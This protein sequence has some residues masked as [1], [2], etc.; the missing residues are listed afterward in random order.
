M[1]NILGLGKM[2]S[3]RAVGA[4]AKI[5]LEKK[6]YKQARVKIQQALALAPTKAGIL[7]IA[8]NIYRES[9]DLG[10][11]L[12]F[13]FKLIK[14]CPKK[15]E[16]YILVVKDLVELR[17][18][19]EAQ[20]WISKG[21]IRF[22]NKQ[23]LLNMRAELQLVQ[24]EPVV[25][26]MPKAILIPHE[27]L[28]SFVRKNS[29]ASVM[30]NAPGSLVARHL[31]QVDLDHFDEP[32]LFHC[33]NALITKN[34]GVHDLAGNPFYGTV[35]TRQKF[36]N[37]GQKCA[38]YPLGYPSKIVTP[39]IADID[40]IPFAFYVHNA[41]SDHFGHLL[42][43]VLSSIY[44]LLFWKSLG[45]AV[46]DIPIIMPL[47]QNNS[48]GLRC[49]SLLRSLGL[50]SSDFLVPGINCKNLFVQ[51]LFVAKPTVVLGGSASKH[52][53]LVVKQFLRLRL[54]CKRERTS[55]NSRQEKIFISRSKLSGDA[56]AIPGISELEILLEENG[57]HIFHPQ[58]YS[59]EEQVD[60]YENASF[61][62]S[63]PGSA[64]HLLYG[65]ELERLQALILLTHQ[66]DNCHNTINYIKQFEAQSLR[67]IA[68]ECLAAENNN[69]GIGEYFTDQKAPELR[70][71]FKKDIR[72]VDLA[73][74]IN[75]LCD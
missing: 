3:W 39:R 15:I 35:L 27:D 71:E 50:T 14:Q 55:D 10:Q 65:L 20:K 58:C 48:R 18:I 2:S 36:V 24:N 64:L 22:P 1:L 44:P 47:N 59:L 70:L 6:L 21:L 16:G 40:F 42:T 67:Y 41:L 63:M 23:I 57:W 7:L 62:C 17:R 60:V 19:A 56:R 32:G 53:S 28:G 51:D 75:E 12:E 11:S 9:G 52:H 43:E 74:R 34:Y 66:G 33:E 46:E 72:P 68:L 38:K 49:N 4:E 8:H 30:S 37:D 54:D 29:C 69:S 5:L 73:I 13:A 45:L 31:G 25:F 26:A 61:L